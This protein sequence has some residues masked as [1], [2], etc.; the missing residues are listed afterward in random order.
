MASSLS[1]SLSFRSMDGLDI[2][3]HESN[4]PAQ[5]AKQLLLDLVDSIQQDELK[6]A[7]T[8]ELKRIFANHERLLN[9]LQSRSEALEQENR[10][11]KTLANDHQH[12]Y[13]KAVREMQFFRKKYEGARDMNK[14]YVTSAITTPPATEPPPPPPQHPLDYRSRSLS[15]ESG[16]SGE[17]ADQQTSTNSHQQQSAHRKGSVT[18][19]NSYPLTPTSPQP[20]AIPNDL[21]IFGKF[22]PDFAPSLRPIPRNS[23]TV[24]HPPP[25]NP[26]SIVYQAH[27]PISPS[28]PERVVPATVALPPPPSRLRQNSTCASIHSAQSSGTDSSSGDNSN[29]TTVNTRDKSSRKQSWQLLQQPSTPTI[30]DPSPKEN[31]PTAA[32]LHSVPMTPVRSSTATNGYTGASMI[33]QRRVDPLIFGG[34]DALWDTISKSKG[35]DVT[36]EKIIR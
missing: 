32:P 7:I 29:N 5:D 34:S 24:W 16:S 27:I 23:T 13:E 11:Y 3:G 17:G 9:M 31:G 12:R 33:Q 2:S 10:D 15:I 4:L 26:G 25:G 1:P 6:H 36:V 8:K 22:D 20:S 28:T 30:A 19:I 14:Q 18:F 21:S 35:S